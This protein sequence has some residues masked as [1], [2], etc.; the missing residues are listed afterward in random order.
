[1]VYWGKIRF[2]Y[3]FRE[4]KKGN[5][6]DILLEISKFWLLYILGRKIEG[7]Y[8]LGKHQGYSVS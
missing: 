3:V 6:W 8:T 1:M 7:M 4:G 5:V 2:A